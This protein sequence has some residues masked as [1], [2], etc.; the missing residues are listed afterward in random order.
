MAKDSNDLASLIARIAMG[1]LR[2][3]S[4]TTCG[5]KGAKRK[6]KECLVSAHKFGS[7]A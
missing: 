1:R 5:M 6:A 7:D 2:A 4:P 3:Q